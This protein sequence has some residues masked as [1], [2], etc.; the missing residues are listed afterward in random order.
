M[1]G[2]QSNNLFKTLFMKTKSTSLFLN[3]GL[4][5]LSIDQQNLINGGSIY[6]DAAFVLGKTLKVIWIFAKDAVTY[7]HSLPPNLKK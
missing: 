2:I 7:Q 6:E 1:D 3:E 5:E 4:S